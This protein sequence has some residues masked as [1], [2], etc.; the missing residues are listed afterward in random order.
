MERGTSVAKVTRAARSASSEEADCVSLLAKTGIS[1]AILE[2]MDIKDTK[3]DH[4][5]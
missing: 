2:G 4:A 3:S 1:S 5:E